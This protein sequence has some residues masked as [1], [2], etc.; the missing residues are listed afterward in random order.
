MFNVH[1]REALGKFILNNLTKLPYLNC[2]L[3]NEVMFSSLM[4]I[5]L[6]RR[7]LLS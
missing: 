6:V 3:I 4:A 2:L 7:C 1:A 5:N